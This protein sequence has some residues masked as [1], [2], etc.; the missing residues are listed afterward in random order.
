MNKLVLF[1]GCLMMG[2]SVMAE[3]VKLMVFGDSLSVGHHIPA[4]DSFC[5]QLERALKE[6]KKDVLV[7]NYSKSGETTEGAVK[8]LSDALEA[9]P[10]GVII[11]LGSNDVFQKRKLE[12]VSK[13][14]QTLISGFMDKEIPVFLIGME[15]PMDVPVEYRLAFREMYSNL[16]LENEL[17]LYPF[18]MDGLWREDGSHVSEEYFLADGIHPSA[19]G[20]AVMVSRIMPAIQQ[21]LYEDVQK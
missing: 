5:S 4:T 15:A 13:D 17:L 7:L 1:L 16:A 12:D 21:F 11:Q 14:L 9:K 3:P 8:K 10:D 20:V 18:F 19:K 2:A 6:H